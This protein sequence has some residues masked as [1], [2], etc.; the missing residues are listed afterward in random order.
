MSYVPDC[1]V[2]EDILAN[3]EQNDVLDGC[4]HKE[5]VVDLQANKLL[6]DILKELKK[7]NIQLSMMTDCDVNNTEL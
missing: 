1:A 6:S 4:L 7:I 2:E 5:L 3:A